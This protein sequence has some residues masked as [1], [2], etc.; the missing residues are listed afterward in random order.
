MKNLMKVLSMGSLLLGL[1]SFSGVAKA[2]ESTKKLYLGEKVIEDIMTIDPE[3]VEFYCTDVSFTFIGKKVKLVEPHNY[4]DYVSMIDPKAQSVKDLVSKINAKSSLEIAKSIYNLLR[5]EKIAYLDDPRMS[6]NL[7]EL[8]AVEDELKKIGRSP[9]EASL[10][11]YVKHPEQT[12][13][14]KGGDCEDLSILYSSLLSAKDIQAGLI[15]F[16]N[17]VMSIFKIDEKEIK[18][19]NLRYLKDSEG[20]YWFPIEVSS[21]AK[22]TFYEALQEGHENFLHEFPCYRIVFNGNCFPIVFENQ[23]IVRP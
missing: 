18:E 19:N 2:Q 12:L 10:K 16:Q 8:L 5:K 21:I 22:K 23:V 11:D 3:K 13:E 1:L 6:K 14:D 15:I 9:L 20:N 17:H 4:Q 7:L